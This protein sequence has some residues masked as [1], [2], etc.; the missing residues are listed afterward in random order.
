MQGAQIR[1]NEAYLLMGALNWLQSFLTK[2]DAGYASI[3]P[4]PW[5]S[6][7]RDCVVIHI[8]V[9]ASFSLRFSDMWFQYVTQPKGCGYPLFL[10]CDTVSKGEG[11][12]NY[13]LSPAGREDWGEGALC[14]HIYA[15]INICKPWQLKMQRLSL[16][17]AQAAQ[18]RRWTFYEAVNIKWFKKTCA[19]GRGIS[20][21]TSTFS[22]ILPLKCVF[23]H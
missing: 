1:R 16:S 19:V 18:R 2:C 12:S 21:S 20:S 9:A 8:L 13:F 7:S 11:N 14:R 23:L 22:T 15:L 4:S 5:P 17:T 6:P 10:N 3:A